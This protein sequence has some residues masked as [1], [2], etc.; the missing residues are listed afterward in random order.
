MYQSR[1]SSLTQRITQRLSDSLILLIPLLFLLLF[2]IPNAAYQY[3]TID[4]STGIVQHK[5]RICDN[6]EACYWMVFTDQGEY[7]NSDTL[8]HLKWDS[9]TL[10]RKIPMNEEVTFTHYGWRVP[11]L[12]MYPNIIEVK[13]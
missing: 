12:S 3:L 11:F 13:H 7:I 6:G 4:T 9:T 2:L 5:E 1:R 8:L 10:Q